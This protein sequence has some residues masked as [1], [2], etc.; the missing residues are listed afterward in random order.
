MDYPH[1]TEREIQKGQILVFTNGCYSDYTLQGVYI[2]KKDF[3]ASEAKK[4]YEKHIEKVNKEYEKESG[5]LGMTSGG[6]ISFL[7]K[8]DFIEAT[9]ALN[10]HLGDYNFE[11]DMIRE[12]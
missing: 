7:L 4:E 8:N 3:Y 5:I 11:I 1:E 9:G 2:S 12:M 10:V 6:F